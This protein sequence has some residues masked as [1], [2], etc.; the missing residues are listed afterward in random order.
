MLE[1]EKEDKDLQPESEPEKNDNI[2]PPDPKEDE[3]Y[4]QDIPED[5][6][7][8]LAEGYGS[9]TEDLTELISNNDDDDD[10]SE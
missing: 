8:I 2:I 4:I 10:D 6:L 1:D 7:D 5:D 9:I 3:P